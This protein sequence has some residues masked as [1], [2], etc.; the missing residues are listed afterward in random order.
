MTDRSGNKLF[1]FISGGE[2]GF[3]EG[4]DLLYK[5]KSSKG[6]Y[7]DEMDNNNY[8]KWLSEKLIPNLPPNSIVVI[9]NAPYHS[10][11]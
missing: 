2:N 10:K 11:Q 6:D 7:H 5:C 8:T 4:A 1:F 9:D 3:I